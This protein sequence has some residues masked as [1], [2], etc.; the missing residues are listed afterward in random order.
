MQPSPGNRPFS[1]V[2]YEWSSG[3]ENTGK[4]EEAKEAAES[5]IHEE[6]DQSI[7]GETTEEGDILQTLHHNLSPSEIH[8]LKVFEAICAYI[9]SLTH[10][11]I[12]LEE[13]NQ[14]LR[15]I[16]TNLEYLLKLKDKP[17]T[18]S[19]SPKKDT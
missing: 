5:E 4:K 8:A 1:E 3:E 2:Y 15:R 14:A 6:E 19:S 9:M 12:L 16:N 11:V 10:E 17:T 13:Q 7:Q 18:S